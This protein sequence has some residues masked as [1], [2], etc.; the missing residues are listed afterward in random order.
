MGSV[1]FLPAGIDDWVEGS[2][3][4][5][6]TLGN[7]LWVNEASLAELQLG[8]VA[9]CIAGQTNVTILDLDDKIG[10]FQ[11]T[12]GTINLRIRNIAPDQV[13]E[14]DIPNLLAARSINRNSCLCSCAS[15]IP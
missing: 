1:S 15:R 6:L 13:Y 8:G 7:R 2:I 14:I 3:N 4:R 9:L 11:V 5:P 10:Q 12:A